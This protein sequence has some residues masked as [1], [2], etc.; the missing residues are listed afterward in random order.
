MRIL[1][2]KLACL[3]FQTALLSRLVCLCVMLGDVTSNRN[4]TMGVERVERIPT[5]RCLVVCSWK[6]SQ[7]SNLAIYRMLKT[8][9]YLIFSFLIKSRSVVHVTVKIEMFAVNVCVFGTC[10]C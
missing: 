4:L 10:P 7:V 5:V 9:L 6:E 8:V 1:V 3:H 2:D